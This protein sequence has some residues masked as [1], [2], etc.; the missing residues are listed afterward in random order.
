MTVFVLVFL[1][2][3]IGSVIWLSA[4]IRNDRREYLP[5]L[6]SDI[7]YDENKRELSFI[8]GTSG[9]RHVFVGRGTAWTTPDGRGVDAM[10]E[11]WLT[12]IMAR[13][14]LDEKRRK[15]E[16]RDRIF[17]EMMRSNRKRR[18]AL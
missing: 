14:L 9:E 6:V 2:I 3:M 10:T 15:I 4:S 11:V 16:E 8:G 7:T 5:N 1:L 17:E 12:D 13:Y 18:N